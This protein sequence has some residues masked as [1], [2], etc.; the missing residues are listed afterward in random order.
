MKEKPKTGQKRFYLPSVLVLFIAT[1]ALVVSILI[2]YQL[3]NAVTLP[4]DEELSGADARIQISKIIGLPDEDLAEMS[5]DWHLLRRPLYG[6]QF[7]AMAFPEQFVGEI[8]LYGTGEQWCFDFPLDEM[9]SG[10]L[11]DKGPATDWWKLPTASNFMG[12]TCGGYHNNIL[13]I[14][15]SDPV[16]YMMYA[17]VAIVETY[18]DDEARQQIE[19][20]F[21]M[22]LPDSAGEIHWL[23]GRKGQ[24]RYIFSTFDV[25]SAD[26]DA[27]MKDWCSDNA[28]LETPTKTTLPDDIGTDWWQPFPSTSR[29]RG[30]CE[31]TVAVDT[32]D[33][34]LWHIYVYKYEEYF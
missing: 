33:E 27:L 30:Q 32:S 11:R 25:A 34:E 18:T 10:G 24:D 16:T 2:T 19:Q 7:F 3:I 15:T 13:V 26:F 6:D 5:D 12:M 22:T 1:F 31:A 28:R 17:K 21:D 20:T 23:I 8:V 4:S 9:Y 14:D 29:I